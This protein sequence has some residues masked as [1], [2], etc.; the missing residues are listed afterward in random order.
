MTR[1]SWEETGSKVYEAGLD[2][3]VLYLDDSEGIPWVGLVSVSDAPSGGDSRAYYLDGVRHINRSAP[4]EFNGTLEAYTYPPE[5]EACEGGSQLAN[6]LN[7]QNQPR[8][9]FGLS[10][11]TLVGNDVDGL[12]HAY[13]IHLIYNALA[14]PSEKANASLNDSTEPMTFSW[15]IS[16]RQI[17]FDDA[18]FGTRYGSHLTLDSRVIYP[19]AMVAIEDILY[20][21]DTEEARLPTPRELLDI[22]IDNALLKI[23]D[24]GDGT[25]TADGPDSAITMLSEDEFQIAW[26]SAVYVDADTYNISSL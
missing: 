2:R 16:T 9:E 8:S 10:Y 25:W 13:K 24:N 20:G 7:I 5:F 15:D 11:R 6:G 4:E 1:L 14:A 12:S 26:P 17:K 21:S 22:F 18:S 3:G 19:W 23:T